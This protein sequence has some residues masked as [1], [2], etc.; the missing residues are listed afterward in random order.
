[1]ALPPGDQSPRILAGPRARTSAGVE[2]V[3]LAA[4]VG[5][6]L[7]PW[8]ESVLDYTLR[9]RPN[10]S[11]AAFE[12]GLCVPRQNG[13][14]SILEARELAG[15]LLFGE[16]LIIHSAHEFKTSIEAMRRLEGLLVESGVRFKPRNSHGQE[17]FE[18][19]AQ[20]L[21]PKGARI[22]F[23]TRT[24][25]GGRGLSGDLV[26]LDEAMI[27]TTEAV[28]AL[29]PTLAARPNPQIW[30]TGS[31]VDENVHAN[32]EVF[33]SVRQRAI[34]GDSPRLCYM[35]WSNKPGADPADPHVRA[36]SNPGVGY[37]ITH[38]YIDAE[39]QALKHSPRTFAVERLGIG[40]WPKMM[41]TR[42]PVIS[43]EAW[44]QMGPLSKQTAKLTGPRTVVV[45]RT[46]DRRTWVIAAAQRTADGRVH[47]EIGYSRPVSDAEAVGAVV[48][49]VGAWNPAVVVISARSS[50]DE[51]TP[52]LERSGIELTMANTAD[53]AEAAGGFLNAALDGRLSHSNQPDMNAAVGSAVKRE[54]PGGGGRFAWDRDADSSAAQLWAV[55]LA[56]WALL[57]FA[58]ETVVPAAPMTDHGH[59]SV[60]GSEFDV[61]TAAF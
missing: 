41:G 50:A 25:A 8:Q 38:E 37:R 27:L 46:S 39:Y 28:G 53:E 12:V 30:Y 47:L 45:E 48:E 29:M 10:G 15:L 3:E 32:G 34:D 40:V 24:K 58:V 23:Q 9:E 5:L 33:S 61:L 43:A 51:L 20:D 54:L 42:V 60:R 7:D 36:Q 35:E 21:V 22:M 26:I 4:S 1:M 13:K 18:I 44:N 55:T 2:A 52:L 56:H 11:W 19:P 17:G 31:A 6:F 14:G 59:T 57:K 49:V 16:Q